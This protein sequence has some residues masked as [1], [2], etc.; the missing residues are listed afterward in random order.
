MRLAVAQPAA[1][2][3]F[4]A[5]GPMELTHG[6]ISRRFFCLANAVAAS[7][8]FCSF[9]PCRKRIECPPCDSAWPTPTTHPW[10]NTPNIART[11]FVCTPS[12][13]TYWLSR[14]RTSACAIVRRTRCIAPVIA[15]PSFFERSFG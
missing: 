7:A 12:S 3:M 4:I 13:S 1:V 10:P 2:T 14:N 6:M 8:M 15:Q 11:N 9:F 5:P